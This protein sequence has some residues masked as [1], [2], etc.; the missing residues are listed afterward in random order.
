MKFIYLEMC[1]QRIQYTPD[2]FKDRKLSS[3]TGPIRE[4]GDVVLNAKKDIRFHKAAENP[5][6]AANYA[7][8]HNL[9][10][11]YTDINDDGI[12]DVV[13]YNQKGEPVM[14]N[15]YGV[16]PSQLPY[17][18]KYAQKYP[19]RSQ[20][21]DIG[22]Y[23]GFTQK[24]RSNQ[25]EGE[26]YEAYKEDL[27]KRG[28]KPLSKIDPNKPRKKSIYQSIISEIRQ[29]LKDTIIFLLQSGKLNTHSWLVNQ[30]PYMKACSLIYNIIV[31]PILW[32]HPQ[33]AGLKQ[34]IMQYTTDTWQRFL[35]F[36][37]QLTSI[38]KDK[39]ARKWLDGYMTSPDFK[40]QTQTKINPD[41]FKEIIENV[42]GCTKD[43]VEKLPTDENLH[44]R[45]SKIQIMDFMDE[46]NDNMNEQVTHL[47]D[48]EF[49][50]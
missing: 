21:F 16:K 50:H 34:Q 2:M 36:K 8:A 12:P 33:F 7:K 48:A 22:G 24:L 47:I 4:I 31:Y 26:D 1:A 15:G 3:F 37:N 25:I 10:P 29:R 46:M 11:S 35:L 42:L 39:E 38:L 32:N 6:T 44:T 27:K 49:D 41:Y 14:I 9:I 13:L 19:T 43:V 18:L 20:R 30:F 17:R 23:H 5:T 40:A 28:Y 45:E